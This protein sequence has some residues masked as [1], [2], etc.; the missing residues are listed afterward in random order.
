LGRSTPVCRRAARY[1]AGTW[2]PPATA[3]FKE[4]LRG[5]HAAHMG[6]RNSTP[7]MLST[8]EI[9]LIAAGVLLV[10]GLVALV[11]R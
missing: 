6:R 7:V 11:R 9:C 1:Q 4:S 10:A 2:S 5:G 8:L 3:D